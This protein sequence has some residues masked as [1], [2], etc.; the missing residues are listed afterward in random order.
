MKKKLLLV[1]LIANMYGIKL[2]AQEKDSVIFLP[3]VTVTSTSIVTKEVEKSFKKSFPNAEN[4]KWYK[5]NKNYLVKFIEKDMKHQTLMAENGS[6][7]YD[8]SY[9]N[10]KNLPDEFLIKVKGAYEDFNI[11]RVANVKEANRNIW[12]VNLES[13]K[14]IV[15]VRLEDEEMEEVEKLDKN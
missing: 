2:L 10:E 1:L 3:P 13:L 9:G 5:I 11:I 8:I 15:L 4:L 7:K 12:V 14:H 6:I